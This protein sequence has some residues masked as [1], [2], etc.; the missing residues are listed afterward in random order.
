MRRRCH[1][2]YCN[3]EPPAEDR[4][5]CDRHIEL[6]DMCEEGEAWIHSFSCSF[7][8]ECCRKGSDAHGKGETAN[9]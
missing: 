6:C 1:H 4:R 7:C 3:A 9:L 8:R 2:L 5:F